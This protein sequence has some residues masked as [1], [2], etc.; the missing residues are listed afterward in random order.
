VEPFVNWKNF[1]KLQKAPVRRLE[2]MV[3]IIP[4]LKIQIIPNEIQMTKSKKNNF[5]TF[6]F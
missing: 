1:L 6:R 4:K 5:L 2:P 3:K